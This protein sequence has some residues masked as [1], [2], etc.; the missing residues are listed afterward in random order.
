MCGRF[1]QH[2]GNTR[3]TRLVRTSQLCSRL[4]PLTA[5]SNLRPHICNS[6]DTCYPLGIVWVCLFLE[7][8]QNGGFAWR[9]ARAVGPSRRRLAACADS[10]RSQR[11]QPARWRRR[12]ALAMSRV[13]QFH[14]R[15]CQDNVRLSKHWPVPYRT[16]VPPRA[17]F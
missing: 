9:W 10:A 12:F 7:N 3:G 2:L 13:V 14:V 5:H 6:S 8:T 1:P 17:A 15:G 16:L 4:V 11:W